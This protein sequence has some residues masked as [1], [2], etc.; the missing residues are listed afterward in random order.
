MSKFLDLANSTKPGPTNGANENYPRELMQLFTV[1]LWELNQDGSQVKTAAGNPVPLL[2]QD[3]VRQVA[4]ALTGWTY[5]TAPG[6]TPRATNWE[7]FAAPMEPR[8]GNHDTTAKSFLGCSLGAGGTV[9]DDLNGVI[10]CLMNHPNIAPFIAVRLIR[11]LV[12]SNPSPGYIQRVANVFAGQGGAARGDLKAVVRAILRDPEARQDTAAATDGRLKEPILQVAG[13]VRAMNGQMTSTQQ[14]TYLFDYMSQSVLGPPSVFSWFSPL[15]RL[16][17]SG[18]LRVGPEF[19]MYRRPTR[20]CAATSSIRCSR[21]E[22][23]TRSSSSRR[24]RP[25]GTTCRAW[26]KR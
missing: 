17:I 5:A 7:Y 8:P 21:V 14:L 2:T 12:K 9:D 20:R 19:Q 4:L 22:E 1:G 3:T 23:A 16:P 15:Y 11:S 18:S 26:S 25:T 13:L 10:D 6:A 24:S